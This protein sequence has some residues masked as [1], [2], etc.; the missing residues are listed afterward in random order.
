MKILIKSRSTGSYHHL[1]G[2]Q[3]VYLAIHN[4]INVGIYD[5]LRLKYGNLQDVLKI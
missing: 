1:S 3:Y 4:C 2:Q 5:L